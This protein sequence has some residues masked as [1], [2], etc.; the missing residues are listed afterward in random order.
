MSG[1]TVGGHF[2]KYDCQEIDLRL[3]AKGLTE[4]DL[5]ELGVGLKTGKFRRLK[6]L[7]LVSGWCASWCL[8]VRLS[9]RAN[10]GR[11]WN[12]WQR[13]SGFSGSSKI[14]LRVAVVRSCALKA[15]VIFSVGPRWSCLK[16]VDNRITD[17]G[18]LALAEA[19]HANSSL[20]W[21]E[22]VRNVWLETSSC[23]H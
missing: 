21:L 13:S 22:L 7:N 16:Q 8:F 12:H 18:A 19:L 20:Q 11:K 14:R 4:D 9:W 17:K 15:V 6:K 10:T 3:T 2:F 5:K 1:V 23:I